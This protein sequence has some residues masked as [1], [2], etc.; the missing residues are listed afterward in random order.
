MENIRWL[1][2]QLLS[3][4]LPSKAFLIRSVASTH[5][6]DERTVI[7]K[8][9]IKSDSGLKEALAQHHRTQAP[10]TIPSTGYDG[11]LQ[12]ARPRH[13]NALNPLFPI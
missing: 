11:A 4:D 8:Q 13:S 1:L 3:L 2:I 9:Q 6:G 10:K 5:G 12:I 7:R